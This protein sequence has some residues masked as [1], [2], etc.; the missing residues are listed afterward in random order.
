VTFLEGISDLAGL[1]PSQIVPLIGQG[2]GEG[3]SAN[4]MYR[5]AVA[6]GVGIRRSNFLQLV[7]QVRQARALSN[8]Y[9]GVAQ[10]E[11]L[12]SQMFADRAGGIAGQNLYNVRLYVRKGPKGGRTVGRRYFSVSTQDVLS[13]EEAMAQA[14]D[15]FQAG[16]T[17][18][19]YDDEEL[20]GSELAAAYTFTGEL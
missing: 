18:E 12:G 14:E 9:A 19:E 20:L 11:A 2:L 15:M 16:Q 7:G 10:N 3:L 4:A 8:V 6:A 13:P 5:Q 1:G 17:H